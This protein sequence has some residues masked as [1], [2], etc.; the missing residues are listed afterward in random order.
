MVL[1]VE[2]T[3][4][5]REVR[6]IGRYVRALLPRLLAQRPELRIVL[7]VRRR[8]IGSV[9][10][11]AGL[12]AMADRVDVRP[13]GE[14]RKTRA[15]AYWYP[16]NVVSRPPKEGAVVAT[17]HDVAPLALPDPRITRWRKNWRWRRL[18]R[19]TAKRATL[20]IVDSSFTAAEVHRVLQVPRDRMHVVLL[21]A[22]EAPPLPAPL[23][24]DALARL[25]IRRPFVLTVG[26]N[27]QRKNLALVERA[28]PR[29]LASRPDVNLVLA[30]PRSRTSESDRE[31]K[32]WRHAVGF[33]SD[34]VLTELYRSADCLVMPSK[35]E[36]FGLPV[37]EA[38]QLGTPVVCA[39]SSSLPEVGGDAVMWVDPDD[40]QA[41]AASITRLM[42]DD[43]HRARLRSLGLA[44]A[45]QFTWDET[46]RRTLAAF[47]EAI[48][49]DAR[50]RRLTP[51]VSSPRTREV[52]GQRVRA[53]AHRCLRAMTQRP[54]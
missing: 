40:D 48:A 13:I 1:A 31:K 9:V 27:D 6:G 34:D 37:L 46:A 7:F 26:A 2:A 12:E 15:D 22:D 3:R 41:L 30:G 47:D 49:I 17:V 38:M 8:D 44:R 32:P 10:H 54:A 5:A 25:G 23:D 52:I 36:G 4:L 45:A 19:A 33:V 18:Y 28:M 14:M 35:Y 29:V 21:A 39:R 11:A 16:W 24:S 53:V 42:D 20:L 50:E 43:T 51:E